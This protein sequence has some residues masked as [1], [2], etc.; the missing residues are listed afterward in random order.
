MQRH[1]L[2]AIILAAGLSQRMGR[3]KPLLPFGD[4]PMLARVVDLFL[5]IAEIRPLIVVTGHAAP[6]I[7]TALSGYPLH[8][9]HNDGYATGGMLS[10]VQTGVRALPPDTAAFFLVL[11]DQPT[12][13]PGTIKALLNAWHEARDSA[14]PPSII[15]PVYQGRRGHPVLFAG[16]CAAEIL[17]LPASATL[18]TC[19]QRHAGN[20]VEVAVEDPSILAD[21]DTPEDYDY[22]LHLWQS[23]HS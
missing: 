7:T 4:K 18:K 13:A 22:A 5:T 14:S 17:D 10:S 11:G 12:V 23:R 19:V 8:F 9:A 6:E 16:H 3:L 21:V 1:S 15:L 20:T 2:A